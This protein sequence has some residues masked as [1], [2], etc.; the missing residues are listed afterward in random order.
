ME[1]SVRKCHIK[2]KTVGVLNSKT[3]LLMVL[4]DT[5]KSKIEGLSYL[6]AAGDHFEDIKGVTM[7]TMVYD[8]HL[9]KSC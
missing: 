8:C 5:E 7:C 3:Y 1:A 2:G 4:L 9:P 6:A